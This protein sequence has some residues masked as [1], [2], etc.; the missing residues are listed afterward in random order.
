MKN[1]NFVKSCCNFHVLL[2]Q[3]Y[4]DHSLR[5]C[6]N[7]SWMT[8]EFIKSLHSLLYKLGCH[9]YSS[10]II[11]AVIKIKEKQIITEFFFIVSPFEFLHLTH[12]IQ[13][14]VNCNYYSLSNSWYLKWLFSP[15]VYFTQVF[16]CGAKIT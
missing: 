13:L 9:F 11:H 8:S 15:F 7:D 5:F 4:F 1:L 2:W 12:S 10:H 3:N 16:W 14:I 6:Y